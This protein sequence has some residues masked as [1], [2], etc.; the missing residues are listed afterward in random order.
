MEPEER[1]SLNV[2]PDRVW[3]EG[4]GRRCGM[5]VWDRVPRGIERGD[6]K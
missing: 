4:V 2:N 6:K 3:D 5:K 1:N